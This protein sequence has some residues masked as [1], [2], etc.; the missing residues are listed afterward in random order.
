MK[1]LSSKKKKKKILNRSKTISEDVS[2]DGNITSDNNSNISISKR[3]TL[4]V[5]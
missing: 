1:K 3:K 4:G 5:R 2:G